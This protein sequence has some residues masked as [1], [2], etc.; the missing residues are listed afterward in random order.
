MQ[1]QVDQLSRRALIW[2][3]ILA[4][5][6]A[7]VIQGQVVSYR[8][9]HGSWDSP[10]IDLDQAAYL[11]NRYWVGLDRPSKGQTP[12]QWRAIADFVGKQPSLKSSHFVM[13][14]NSTDMATAVI[15][16]FVKSRFGEKVDIPEELVADCEI[17][18][19][20]HSS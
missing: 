7:P 17:N 10:R 19:A 6:F 12:P 1:I 8:T 9:D 3:S 15:R 14:A 2:A 20:M 4:Q 18:S 13:T 11:M 5:G 16:C